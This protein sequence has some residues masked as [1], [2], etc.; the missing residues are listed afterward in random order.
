MFVNMSSAFAV[1][2]VKCA[3]EWY[4][5]IVVRNFRLEVALVIAA[6]EK[7]TDKLSF[8]SKPRSHTE[9]PRIWSD[10]RFAV[11][12]SLEMLLEFQ[13]PSRSRPCWG[14]DVRR[15]SSVN[16]RKDDD[17]EGVQ[18]GGLADDA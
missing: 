1:H 3:T 14:W 4:I 7:E 9:S 16:Q 10:Q 6:W 11:R 13:L 2:S 15:M 8:A 5:Q 17:D 18:Q 12:R